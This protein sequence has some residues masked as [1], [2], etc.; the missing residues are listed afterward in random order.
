M[1]NTLLDLQTQIAD[2]LFRDDLTNQ[3]ASAVNRAIEHY[4]AKRFWFT[5]QRVTG[6]CVPD[7]EY[8]AYPMGLRVLDA[9]FV[10]NGIS[11]APPGYPLLKKSEAEIEEFFQA[12]GTPTQPMLYCTIGEQIRLYP[13][14]NLAY[15]LTFVGI[16]DVAP[17]LV[18]PT[19]VNAWSVVGQ[20]L[21]CARAK[22]TI[23]RDILRDAQGAQADLLAQTE[24]LGR[25]NAETARRVGTSRFISSEY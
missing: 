16:F 14:P 18:N 1:T 19:D 22:Y 7:N 9:V 25:L 24:A 21:I 12:V 3:I 2:E 5:E 15:P 4:A 11:G 23:N 13:Q 17:A 10:A 8:M 6:V 20:D